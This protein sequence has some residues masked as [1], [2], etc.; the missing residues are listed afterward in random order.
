MRRF[1]LGPF[2]FV[3]LAMIAAAFGCKAN[4]WRE[5]EAKDPDGKAV[6]VLPQRVTEA[7]ADA[8]AA[9][10]TG[11][12]VDERTGKPRANLIVRLDHFPEARP[13]ATNLPICYPRLAADFDLGTVTCD[14]EGSQPQRLVAANVAQEC[15]TNPQ[16]K[17]SE[18]TQ[19]LLLPGCRRATIRMHGF[20]PKLALDVEQKDVAS[21]AP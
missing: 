5:Q 11:F 7:S 10:G 9:T 13:G 18:P 6:S 8:V 21:S 14:A 1:L 16:Q 19:G 4:R 3:T 20:E 15:Y 12:D 2:A 17:R